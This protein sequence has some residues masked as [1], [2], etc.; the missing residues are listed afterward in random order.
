MK[1]WLQGRLPTRA[2]VLEQK[3][4][5]AISHRLHDPNLWHINRHS[6]A[7]AVGVGLFAALIPIPA[8]MALGALLAILFRGNLPIAVS[9]AW[10]SNPFT[11]PFLFYAAYRIG[12]FLLGWDRSAVVFPTSLEEL[13]FDL[14]HLWQPIL[15]GCVLLALLTGVLSYF[16]VKLAWRAHLWHRIRT[17]ARKRLAKL[18]Q[19]MQ[20]DS[21]PKKSK[22]EK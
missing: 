8:Q 11:A 19:K 6:V 13:S 12:T 10:V 1:K 7:A 2:W 14:V 4:L 5:G 22:T 18:Q 15:L 16:L 17:R 21:E 3:A 20:A 9:M